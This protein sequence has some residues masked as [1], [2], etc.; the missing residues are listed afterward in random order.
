MTDEEIITVPLPDDVP[1]SLADV[2]DALGYPVASLRSAADRGDLPTYSLVGRGRYTDRRYVIDW[3][4][5]CRARAAG[6]RREAPA[7]QQ[8]DASAADAIADG[9]IGTRRPRSRP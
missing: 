5:T 6:R 2:A 1:R 7:E 8:A 9:L 4:R 3:I